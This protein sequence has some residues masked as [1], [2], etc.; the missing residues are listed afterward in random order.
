[1]TANDLIF[2]PQSRH[3]MSGNELQIA[4][5][6]Y[7]GVHITERTFFPWNIFKNITVC[8]VLDL[9]LPIDTEVKGGK[10]DDAYYTEEGY[11]LPVFEELDDALEFIDKF[12]A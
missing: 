1:M 2:E 4:T 8:Y 9:V 6:H 11:G 10:M 7:K 12:R 5:T 3:R